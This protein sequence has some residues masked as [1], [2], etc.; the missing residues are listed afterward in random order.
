MQNRIGDNTSLPELAV[1]RWFLSEAPYS[2]QGALLLGLIAYAVVFAF[3]FGFLIAAACS[4]MAGL[5]GSSAS[6]IS[7]GRRGVLI[8]SGLILGESLIGVLMAGI[9]GASGSQTPLAIVGSGFESTSE[10]LGLAIFVMVCTGFYWQVLS[11][12]I[13]ARQRHRP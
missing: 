9:I 6:P 4:Y 2:P 8:A 11:T 3:L 7:P 1:V 10:W 5:V 12:P 13:I